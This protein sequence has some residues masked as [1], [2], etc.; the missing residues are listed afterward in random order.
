VDAPVAAAETDRCATAVQVA[1]QVPRHEA[2]LDRHRQI[3]VDRAVP[4]F[5]LEIGGQVPRQ[6]ELDRSVAGVQVP[7]LR[8]P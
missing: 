1:A 7:I 2:A 3:G 5:G 8:D 6:P 4:G